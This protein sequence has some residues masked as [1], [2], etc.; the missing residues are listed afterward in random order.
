MFS[1]ALFVLIDCQFARCPH[2]SGDGR[3][4][5]GRTERASVD[6]SPSSDVKKRLAALFAI[7]FSIGPYPVALYPLPLHTISLAKVP[8]RTTWIFTA[9]GYLDS[10]PS[11]QRVARHDEPEAQTII[12]KSRQSA[13]EN[14]PDVIRA[15]GGLVNLQI[16]GNNKRRDPFIPENMSNVVREEAIIK[17]APGAAKIC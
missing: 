13:G 17:R 10:D 15:N 5:S 7:E 1:A 14:A 6:K 12:A 2:L 8:T 9:G 4:A 3:C 16:A 11:Y